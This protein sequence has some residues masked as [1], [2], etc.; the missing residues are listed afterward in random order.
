MDRDVLRTDAYGDPAKLM[1]RQAL[2]AFI[3][4]TRTAGRIR[5]VLDLAGDETV[6]DIGSGNG[7]DLAALRTDGHH[8]PIFGT[9]LSLGMVSSIAPGTAHRIN[10]EAAHLPVP[11]RCA[12]VVSA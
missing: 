3:D 9:D 7:R 6:V 5:A 8:G 2:W 1:A 10:A 11:D 4:T 12:D